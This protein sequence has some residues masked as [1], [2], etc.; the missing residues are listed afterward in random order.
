MVHE[1]GV[2][3]AARDLSHNGKKVGEKAADKNN[4]ALLVQVW[5]RLC[6]SNNQTCTIIIG[7]TQEKHRLIYILMFDSEFTKQIG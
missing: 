3:R 1:A 7:S 6:L 4:K 2:R 5:V